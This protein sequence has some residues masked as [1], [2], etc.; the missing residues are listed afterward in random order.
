MQHGMRIA[1]SGAMVA[2]HRTDVL[3][4]N[5]ANVN[6]VGFKPDNSTTR[7]RAVVR[8]EDNIQYMPS[9]P[10]LERLGA[11]VLAGPRRSSFRQGPMQT[12]DNPLDLAIEGKGFFMVRLETEQG[13]QTALTRDGRFTR[14]DQGR[15]V[16][17]AS[18]LPV[19]GPGQ[20][21]IF[22]PEGPITIDHNGRINDEDGNT[23]ATIGVLNVEDPHT[24]TKRGEGLFTAPPQ[25]LE[26]TTDALASSA[27]VH[28]GM[29]EGSAVDPI[30]AMMD[31]TDAGRAVSGNS[32]MIGYHDQLLDQAINTFARVS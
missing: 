22:L 31:V 16:Q 20:Q 7:S 21:P 6:T 13:A 17:A 11:G 5:L 25:A 19:L 9:N 14:D 4:N 23:L 10:L 29:V 12:T 15:L 18:G 3:A 8:V 30:R 1:A 24:L 27:R 32:R 2:L 28:Q 26:G